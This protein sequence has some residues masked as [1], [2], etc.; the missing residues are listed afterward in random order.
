DQGLRRCL[1]QEAGAGKWRRGASY[2]TDRFRGAARRDRKPARN[3]GVTATILLVDDEPDLE[4]L[5]TQKFRREIR[6]GSLSF[7]FAHDGVE[8]LARSAS[9]PALALVLCEITMPRAGGLALP[10]QLPA[11]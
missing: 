11:T 4:A 7:V 9:G 10:E 5:V 6:D 1:D 8:A 3:R 2:A